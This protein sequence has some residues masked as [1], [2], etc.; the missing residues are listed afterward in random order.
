MESGIRHRDDGWRCCRSAKHTQVLKLLHGNENA[1]RGKQRGLKSRERSSFILRM[2]IEVRAQVKCVRNERRNAHVAAV[3]IHR[4]HTG[5]DYYYCTKY[6]V[7]LLSISSPE[8]KRWKAFVAI[9]FPRSPDEKSTPPVDQGCHGDVY[10]GTTL[11]S[12]L[13]MGSDYRG[14]KRPPEPFKRSR[15]TGITSVVPCQLWGGSQSRRRSEQN[16]YVIR[17]AVDKDVFLLLQALGDC[18]RA[19]RQEG[20]L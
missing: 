12:K 7:F 11:R 5:R 2:H 9:S 4:Y 17:R 18:G 1:S 16:Q 15:K 19:S 6:V 14:E 10:H 3:T 20:W 8:Q 13:T